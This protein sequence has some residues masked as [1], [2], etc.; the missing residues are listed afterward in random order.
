[1][2]QVS[3]ILGMVQFLLAFTCESEMLPRGHAFKVFRSRPTISCVSVEYIT[4][5]TKATVPIKKLL[6]TL[7]SMTAQY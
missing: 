4:I 5:E 6:S 3:P 7:P 2:N 1:M